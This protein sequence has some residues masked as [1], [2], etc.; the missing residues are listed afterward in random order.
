MPPLLTHR[1]ADF[2]NVDSS[3]LPRPKS[4]NRHWRVTKDVEFRD[5]CFDTV[6]DLPSGGDDI[7]CRLVITATVTN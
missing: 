6:D 2:Q 4:D 3:T 5:F 7:S 1:V